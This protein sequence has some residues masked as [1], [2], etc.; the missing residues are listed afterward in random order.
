LRY[1]K[2]TPEKQTNSRRW[3]TSL[4]FQRYNLTALCWA[5]LLCV[6]LPCCVLAQSKTELEARRKKITKEIEVTNKLLTK[7]TREKAA[8]YERFITL[9]NQIE[10][11]ES[12]I[13]VLDN[14]V[15]AADSLIVQSNI[16]VEQLQRDLDR[17]KEDYGRTLRTAYRRKSLTS[18][19]LFLLSAD[20]LNQA[21]RR[22]L[23]LRKYD[24][25]QQGQAQAL[26]YSQQ[27]LIS[28]INQIHQIKEEK[29]GL[30]SNMQGQQGT[31][32]EEMNNKNELLQ[33]LTEDE[34]RLREDLQQKQAARARLDAAIERMIADGIAQKTEENNRKKKEK[35]Q[36]KEQGKVATPAPAP[37][38]P[39]PTPARQD[40]EPQ[41]VVQK[42]QAVAREPERPA[43]KPVEVTN[44]DEAAEDQVSADFRRHRGKLPNP[45]ENGV[46]TRRFGRQKH[47][48]LKNIEITNN[49]VDIRT[50]ED[51]PVQ[52][53]FEGKVVGV[54]YIP[55]HDYTVILQHGDY[56]TVY[57][58]LSTSSLTKGQIVGEGQ[59][60]GRVS[61]NPI[62]GAAELHFE[63]WH[64]KERENP[65]SW[66]R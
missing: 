37:T 51:A 2:T 65:A 28:R 38:T 50:S 60:I 11:R 36:K 54:Q 17:M 13:Q 33:N 40:P 1:L 6:L 19:L 64:E 66:L 23:F 8:T 21:F 55:G 16:Q 4:I 22:W 39:S 44:Y 26:T 59:T 25:Y 56:Y 46:I 3:N 27:Q 32:A 35:A 30:L 43:P 63:L 49:G 24:Q 20:N 31:L 48:T 12:L 18:P 42:P 9:Q 52:A 14:E 58:N 61:T 41:P 62:S 47:P 15:V 45:V 57:A 29:T 7:T 53:V 34:G 10:R 5:S